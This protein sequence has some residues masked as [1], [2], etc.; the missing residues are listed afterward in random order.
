[1][2][3]YIRHYTNHINNQN[4]LPTV[5]EIDESIVILISAINKLQYS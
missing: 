1:L 2:P 3:M 4:E 5:Q